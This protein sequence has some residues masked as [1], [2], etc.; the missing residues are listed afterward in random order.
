MTQQRRVQPRQPRP[1]QR[2]PQSQPGAAQS[3]GLPPEQPRKPQRGMQDRDRS[4]VKKLV[5]AGCVTQFIVWVAAVNALGADSGSTSVPTNNA[6]TPSASP[7]TS[8]T[9]TPPQSVQK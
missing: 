4:L 7:T 1:R 2:G 5:V 9:P 8:T 6:L 3:P